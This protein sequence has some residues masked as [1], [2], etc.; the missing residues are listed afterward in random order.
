M[1]GRRDGR[2]F[3]APSNRSARNVRVDALKCLAIAMVVLTHLLNL[4]SEF[5]GLAPWLVDVMVSFSMP[6]FAFLSGYVLFGR[7]G[8]DPLLF[9]RGKAL[10]LLGTYMA[11]VVVALVVRGFELSEWPRR[12]GRALVD[13]HAGFQMWFLWTL[14]CLLA[15]FTLVRQ[16]S[17]SDSWLLGVALALG[18]SLALPL[19]HLLGLDKIA[20][21]YPFLVLGYFVARHRVQL[22]RFDKPAAMIALLGFPVLLLVDDPG[23]PVRFITAIAGIIAAWAVYRLLPREVVNAQAWVGRRTLGVYG[24]Q[25]VVLPLFVIDAG[26][27]GL[28]LSWA[29]V[30]AATLVLTVVLE[31]F[32]VTRML[33]LGQW[34][35][36]WKYG[37]VRLSAQTDDRL[38]A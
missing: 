32:G 28:T 20:W 23:V 21:L 30:L 7:E 11:W 29:A 38:S 35:K 31:R 16:V 1:S 14:F 25:M 36:R 24:W 26:W 12:I 9:L 34:P 33:F 4:R 37:R 13:P 15:I 2:S 27:T 5:Q 18:A 3:V 6:L 10:S 17:T 19:P 22:R 8:D